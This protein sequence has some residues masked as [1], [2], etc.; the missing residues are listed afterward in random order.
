MNTTP[1]NITTRPRTW[2]TQPPLKR[3]HAVAWL[4]STP[5]AMN[6]TEKPKT[7]SSTPASTRPRRWSFRS[8]PVSPVT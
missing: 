6:T 2:V 8:A 3:S 1:M 5:T 7:N 4:N